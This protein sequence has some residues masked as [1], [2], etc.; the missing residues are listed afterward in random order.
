ML[1]AVSKLCLWLVGSALLALKFFVALDQLVDSFVL[2]GKQLLLALNLDVVVFS[3]RYFVVRRHRGRR[4]VGDNYW[5][6]HGPQKF[7]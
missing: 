4:F 7:G 6:W 5:F 2:A 3:E 1:F